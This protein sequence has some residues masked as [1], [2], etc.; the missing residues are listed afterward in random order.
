MP[1]E[2][3]FVDESTSLE[4]HGVMG[5]KW[6]VR[7]DRKPQGYQSKRA[8]KRQA[9]LEQKAVKKFNE[10]FSK[11]WTKSYNKAADKQNADLDR[12]NAKHKQ[13]DFKDINPGGD[14]S[15]VDAKTRKAWNKYVTECGD[16]WVKNYSETLLSDF[17]EHPTLGKEWVER[18]PFMD[19]YSGWKVEED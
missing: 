19:S 16:A 17:G 8:A 12:I 3:S 5:M 10:N 14:N 9:K 11:N 2:V 18:A 15:H 6:G 7:K 4:H 1:F 13:Q